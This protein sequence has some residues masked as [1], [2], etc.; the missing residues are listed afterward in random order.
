LIF[1]FECCIHATGCTL[2]AARLVQTAGRVVAPC[3]LLG[4]MGRKYRLGTVATLTSVTT[5]QLGNRC[6]RG[7]PLPLKLQTVI[8]RP[9]PATGGSSQ[10]TIIG[11][12]KIISGP[13]S[14][15]EV[16]VVDG[17]TI[18]VRGQQYRLVGF[19]TP[20]T[21]SARCQWERDLGTRATWRLRQLVAQGGLRLQR[22]PCACPPGT[23]G[24]Y[25][26]NYGRWCGTLTVAGRDVGPIL[27]SEGL[28]RSYVCGRTSCPPRQG[29]C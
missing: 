17:D 3:C 8:M 24:S 20:E 4:A 12:G 10:V 14:P 5:A 16:H 29:W 15:G 27:I 13:L 2:Y 11:G 7:D 25:S 18:S 21:V 1:D 28:A 9:Q 23:E 6:R 26:C 22:M 19:D